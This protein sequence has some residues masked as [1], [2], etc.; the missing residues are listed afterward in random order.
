PQKEPVYSESVSKAI[1]YISSNYQRHDLSRQDI[2]AHVF[3]SEKYLSS[4]FARET[5]THLIAYINQYRIQKAID[6]LK[7]TRLPVSEIAFKVGYSSV[8]N[9]NKNFKSV[10]ATSP[11]HYRA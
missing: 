7:Q 8:Q 3:L 9:F 10:T 11:S 6:L 1:R 2:A 5:G 4:L